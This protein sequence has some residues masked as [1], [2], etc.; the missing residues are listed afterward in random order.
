MAKELSRKDRYRKAYMKAQDLALES[1]DINIHQDYV[2][3]ARRYGMLVN[4][5]NHSEGLMMQLLNASKYLLD[6]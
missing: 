1:G 4:G 2:D 3:K 5:G 6:R